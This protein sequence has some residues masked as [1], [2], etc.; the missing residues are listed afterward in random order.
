MQSPIDGNGGWLKVKMSKAGFC[1]LFLI[2]NWAINVDL[3]ALNTYS[4]GSSCLNRLV[5]ERPADMGDNKMYYD[6]NDMSFYFYVYSAYFS[7]FVNIKK[8]YAD[9]DNIASMSLQKT[10]D[11]T[12]LTVIG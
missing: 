6:P 2:S 7:S 3:I 11:T 12:N 5:N 10:L 4:P 9:G 8:V 1:V